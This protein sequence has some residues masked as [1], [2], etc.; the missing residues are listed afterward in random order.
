MGKY[1]FDHVEPAPGPRKP[2]RDGIPV[3]T[4]RSQGG[5]K[6]QCEKDIHRWSN[7]K[8]KFCLD[9]GKDKEVIDEHA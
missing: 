3:G 7:T 8:D 5:L 4:L 6:P 2:L 1:N 9:C